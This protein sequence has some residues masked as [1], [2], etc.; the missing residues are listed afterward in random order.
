MADPR[1]FLVSLPLRIVMALFHDNYNLFILR[2]EDGGRLFFSCGELF[3]PC[4]YKQTLIYMIRLRDSY[5]IFSLFVKCSTGA[6]ILPLPASV[7]VCPVVSDVGFLSLRLFDLHAASSPLILE[8]NRIVSCSILSRF[9]PVFLPLYPA[10]FH[11]L[12]HSITP[13]LCSA[14]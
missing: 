8:R 3:E 11:S 5:T 2:V 12:S 6:S 13:S 4:K 1:G 7:S 10:S 14:V 9:S